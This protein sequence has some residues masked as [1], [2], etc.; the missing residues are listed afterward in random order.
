MT[1]A[2]LTLSPLR[3]ERFDELRPH[4]IRVILFLAIGIELMTLVTWLPETLRVWWGANPGEMGDFEIFYRKAASSTPLNQYSPGLIFLMRPLSFLG[5]AP[6]FQVYTAVNVAALLAVAYLAQRPVR[7]LEARV[8]VFLAVIALPQAHWALRTGHFVPVLALLAL[9]GFLLTE[10]RPLLAGICFG[11]LMLKP[12]YLP[13]PI[14]Y[15]LWTRN[16]RAVLGAAGTILVLSAAGMATIGAD[17][18]ID[19]LRRLV[20]T[21]LDH[22]ELYVPAQQAIQYSWQG[23]FLSAGLEPSPLL[24]VDL[25]VLSFGAV[26]LVWMIGA[27]SAAKVAAALG[28]LLLAPYSTFYNWGMIAVAGALLLRAD[29][30]PRALIP[31]VLAL[32]V[33]AA[34]AT[35]KATPYPIPNLLDASGTYGLYWLQPFALGAVFLLAVAGRRRSP[36]QEEEPAAASE[37]T[38]EHL[39]RAWRTVRMGPALQLV[40]PAA[41]WTI[42]AVAAAAS[43]Y[44]LSAFVSESPPF[45]PDLFGRQA[46]LRALPADFPV[47]PAARVKDAGAGTLLPYRVE[48][49]TDDSVSEVAGLFGERL[50]NGTWQILLADGDATKVRLRTARLDVTGSMDLFGEV[51]I[52]RSNGGSLV[53]LEFT[54]LPTN[55]VPGFDDWLAN[56]DTSQLEDADSLNSG[57]ETAGP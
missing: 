48:W 45:Q 41:F 2:T 56:R 36:K 47:P 33:I 52:V 55:K 38:T 57:G 8:V 20:Q 29:V 44:M 9:S 27:P 50:D 24:T 54:P 34:A 43:G 6:A 46:V 4:I 53:S 10:R 13:I 30:R 3:S 25:L 22:S 5:L 1:L 7:S 17:A 40:R 35:Q 39:L 19:Q 32:G 21:G 28:I 31:A 18:F 12:Q 42:V 15:L 14:L 16:W 23:F 49:Q 51:K 37:R 11:L 26:V